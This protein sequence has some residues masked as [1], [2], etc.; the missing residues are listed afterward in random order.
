MKILP[1]PLK[2][3]GWQACTPGGLVSSIVLLARRGALKGSQNTRAASREES[4]VYYL[5]KQVEWP[6][7]TLD[8]A[9]G[10]CGLGRWEVWPGQVG[11]GLVLTLPRK[12]FRL[13]RSQSQASTDN[14]DNASAAPSS[15]SNSNVSFQR[16]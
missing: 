6:E 7:G 10:G 15:S 3:L 11:V 16:G 13:T 5:R 1:Q 4:Q 8:A 14:A 9:G 12:S 2:Y